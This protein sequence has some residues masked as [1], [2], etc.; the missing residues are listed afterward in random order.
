MG[1]DKIKAAVRRRMRESGESYTAARREVVRELRA[2]G[3]NGPAGNPGVPTRAGGGGTPLVPASGVAGFPPH[4]HVFISYVR[5][6]SAKADWLQGIFE[7]AGIP[8]WRD[9]TSLWPGDD[10][11]HK[12][13]D[14]ITGDALV[15]IACFSSNSAARPKSYMYEELSLAIDELRQRRP[16]DPWLIPALFDNCEIPHYELGHGRTLASIQWANLFGES[17][18]QE[19]GRLVEAVQR[20]LERFGP[21]RPQGPT[22]QEP[23]PPSGARQGEQRAAQPG[24]PPDRQEPTAH[25]F[26]ADVVRNTDAPWNMFSSHDYWRRNYSKLQ[27]E[28][29]E[30]IRCVSHFFVS[31]L[32]GQPPVQR[33]IDVGSGTNLYPALLMLP[34]TEQILLADFSKSNV[35]W[36]HDQLA[37]S[38]SPRARRRFSSPWPWARFWREMRKAE[39]YSDVNR[40][41]EQLQEAC[42][43]EPGYAGI[44]QLSVF[45]LPKARWNLG[46][47][48]FVAESITEDPVEFR[49]AVA[50][51]V[52]ALTPGAPFAAAFMAGSDG[53]PVDG[54]QFP[55]LSINPGDVRQHLTEL[56]VREPSVDLLET[57]DRVR[58]G[59]TGV[60]I[61]TGF[62]GNQ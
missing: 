35:D 45:D 58:D 26:D 19:A 13:R 51:F 60:I 38:I 21:R 6:D 1:H 31:A 55:A 3:G 16:Q 30:I 48:F 56:G 54:T 15:F 50:A 9:R 52:G 5:A 44:E 62:V 14:A 33:A 27:A 49:A 2:A 25:D 40:P 36:L 10:W 23:T 4:G 7:A 34:W 22:A 61:A 59:Y 43:S 57:S 11:R 37:E 17:R 29:R 53:Y 42:V 12:I 39:G 24:S 8:V 41:R 28:D 20:L 32:A 46:T 18:D 47:M